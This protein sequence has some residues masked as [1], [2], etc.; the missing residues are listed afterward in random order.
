MKSETENTQMQK[1]LMDLFYEIRIGTAMLVLIIIMQLA[2]SFGMFIGI[3]LW[4]DYVRRS[5]YSVVTDKE[6]QC[7]SE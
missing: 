5:E 3:S 4:L 6:E 2:I 7:Q 1:A